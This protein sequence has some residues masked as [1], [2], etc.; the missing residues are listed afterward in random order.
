M[1]AFAD[2]ESTRCGP[3]APSWDGAPAAASGFRQVAESVV[4][5][6]RRARTPHCRDT[7]PEGRPVRMEWRTWQ[8]V[9][10]EHAEL[11]GHLQEI[12]RTVAA[13]EHRAP[14]PRPGRERYFRRAGPRGRIRVVTELAGTADR[15]VTA[16]PQEDDPRLEGVDR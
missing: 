1:L 13:P 12:M 14:D 5:A 6:M 8:H 2:L 4:N 3:I 16:F 11:E 9:V 15:V 7:K 10:D